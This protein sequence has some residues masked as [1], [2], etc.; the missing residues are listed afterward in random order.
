MGAYRKM[1]PVEKTKIGPQALG[2]PFKVP[3]L[4]VTDDRFTQGKNV[5]DYKILL[6]GGALEGED[7][8]FTGYWLDGPLV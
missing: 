5:T 8:Q 7:I 6:A 3:S 4:R 2:F 1:G